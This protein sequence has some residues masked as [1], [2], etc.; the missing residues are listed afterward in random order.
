MEITSLFSRTNELQ[1]LPLFA[2][3]LALGLL[4]GLERER[5][6]AARAGLRTF[7]LVALLGTLLAMVGQQMNAPWLVAIG[8]AGVAALIIRAYA[9]VSNG[10]DPG[11]TTQAALMICYG[12]GVAVW[13]GF[14]SL[15]IMLAIIT[16]AL[17]YLKPELQSMSKSLTRRDLQS[18]LQFGVLSFIILPILPD[19]DFGPHSAFN[20][21]QTWLMVVLVSGVSLAGY[22]ALRLVGQ[23]FGAPLLGFLGGLVSSTATT[24]VYA[25]HAKKG[26]AT[27]MARLA[28]V[29]I[30]IANLVV[31]LR[32]LLISALVS[33]GILPHILPVLLGGFLLGGL[34]TLWMW[35]KIR[36][37][38]D[39]PMPELTNP[40]EIKTALGFGVMYALVLLCAA[41]LSNYAGNSGLYGLA[42][43]AGLTD[44]DAISLSSLRLFEM[45]KLG[46]H[47]VVV[48]ITVAFLSNLVFKFGLL[49]FVGGAALTKRCAPGM[50]AM[51]LGMIAGLLL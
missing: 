11:T 47:Q 49:A 44:V 21:Y 27:G 22:V 45:G 18:I 19:K 28:V 32:L 10:D 34:L 17:L 24:L 42:L 37:D 15:A 23:R 30:L 3:S 16:T 26:E 14:S 35:R 43:V 50:L 6:L 48:T 4:M 20:P 29:V 38:G 40:T 46:A 31:L 12:L 7:A 8:L 13:F 33:P 51:A 9:G 2:T 5:S 41:W 39:P 25:R 36:R 1:Y